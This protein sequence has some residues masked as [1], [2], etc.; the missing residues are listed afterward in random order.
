M[1]DKCYL[2]NE[3]IKKTFLDKIVGT[4]IKVKEK[5][6]NKNI[7]VC[8]DCQKKHKDLKKEIQKKK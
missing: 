5:D 3:E 7:F 1:S 4:I 8:P 2:C 6:K